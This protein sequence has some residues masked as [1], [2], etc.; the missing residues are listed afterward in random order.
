MSW[1]R[2][3]DERLISKWTL[4]SST[5][6]IQHCTLDTHSQEEK[7]QRNFN[8]R[9]MFEM[10]SL[11][12]RGNSVTCRVEEK[13]TKGQPYKWI[14]LCIN[15][16]AGSWVR[17][18]HCRVGSQ[19]HEQQIELA[20]VQ[21]VSIPRGQGDDS[22]WI[23]HIGTGDED[24]EQARRRKGAR[25]GLDNHLGYISVIDR[26]GLEQGECLW[27]LNSGLAFL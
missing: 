7:L 23:G 22:L 1:W 13:D 26:S 17:V 10:N 14:H 4:F 15:I 8:W 2:I 21:S 12:T 9:F 19:N 16:S 24:R 20:L 3:P 6:S 18:G 5:L 27:D 11:L 25:I